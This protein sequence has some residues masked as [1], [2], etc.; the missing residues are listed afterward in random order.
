MSGCRSTVNQFVW[1][2]GQRDTPL[3][4]HGR[5]Q[6]KLVGQ[7]LAMSE[8]ISHIYSSD[9]VRAAEVGWACCYG[10]NVDVTFLPRPQTAELIRAQLPCPLDVTMDTR[11]R[12]RVCLRRR[13][14]GLFYIV[15]CLSRSGI[16]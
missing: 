4:D 15:H 8:T 14:L 12:E 16:W 3:S 7:R 10:H 11:L 2:A 6:G 5:R 9:L 1:F 13:Q